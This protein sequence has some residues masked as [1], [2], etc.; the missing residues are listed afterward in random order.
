MPLPAVFEHATLAR[1]EDRIREAR[2]RYEEA[3]RRVGVE[4][5]WQAHTIDGD[6]WVEAHHLMCRRAGARRIHWADG[7]TQPPFALQQRDLQ[8]GHY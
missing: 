2:G 7:K 8:D 3:V 6:S 4:S 5:S 1:Y